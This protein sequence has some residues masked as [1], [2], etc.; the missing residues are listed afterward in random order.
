[1]SGLVYLREITAHNNLLTKLN[2][3][4]LMSLRRL[5]FASNPLKI[6]DIFDLNDL[7]TLLTLPENSSLTIIS[8]ASDWINHSNETRVRGTADWR[9]GSPPPPPP[10]RPEIVELI[11]KESLV[12]QSTGKFGMAGIASSSERLV[13]R[14][15]VVPQELFLDSVLG[16]KFYIDDNDP[17]GSGFTFATAIRV[18]VVPETRI[19]TCFPE[20]LITLFS[21]RDP[22][23]ITIQKG[24]DSTTLT[25]IRLESPLSVKYDG[26]YIVLGFRF[27][28]R[29]SIMRYYKIV[30]Q[31]IK[32]R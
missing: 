5:I 18:T 24:T 27:N 21:R 28:D 25:S 29:A 20:E 10:L 6:L 14:V 1:V 30:P 17:G 11:E 9:P 4:G 26:L 15:I 12:I 3:S 19:L 23:P 2:I 16:Q 13:L 22:N 32:T 7:D 8:S 31:H